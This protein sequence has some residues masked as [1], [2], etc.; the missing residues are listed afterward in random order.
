MGA[1]GEIMLGQI[2]KEYG[3]SPRVWA[4]AATAL[5]IIFE[6][7]TGLSKDQIFNLVIT[8]GV[9]IAGVSIRPPRPTDTQVKS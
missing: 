7:K 8:I 9:A 4:A 2:W 3:Q 6:D 1:E 5:A